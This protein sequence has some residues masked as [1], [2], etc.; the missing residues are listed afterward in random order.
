MIFVTKP[1]K[2]GVEYVRS[3]IEDAPDIDPESMRPEEGWIS[4]KDR[5]PAERKNTK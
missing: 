5:L 3:L 4:V 1:Y 2:S